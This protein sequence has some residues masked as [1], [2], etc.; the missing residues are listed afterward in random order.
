MFA[1]LSL[2]SFIYDVLE[3]FYFADE[4]TKEI[5]NREYGIERVETFHVLTDTD[6]TALKLIFASDPNSE[7]RESKFRDIIFKIT[8]SSKIYR[9]FLEQEKC[10]K[11]KTLGGMKLK[12]LITTAS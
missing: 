12:L 10:R 8:T 6:S 11:R 9:R 2:K 3:T 5:W 4:N 7:I 1:K